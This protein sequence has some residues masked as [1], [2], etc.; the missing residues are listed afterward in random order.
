MNKRFKILHTLTLSIFLLLATINSA[1]ASLIKFSAS[2]DGLQANAGAGT[3]S[4]A[5]GWGTMFLDDVT[6]D[7]SW[8]ISWSGLQAAVTA[9]HFHGPALPNQNAGVQVTIDVSSNPSSGNTVL[10]A[11][12]ASDLMN[13][14]WYVNIHSSMFPAGEIR[15]Q[16]LQDVSAPS[17]ILILSLSLSG[18]VFLR[19]RTL[20]N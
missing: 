7:F 3:G 19:R 18:F 11:Q 17:T 12:Q 1:T 10:T 2:L 4:L 13:S 15:G 8:E 14:L 20:K 16:V 9:A 6:N 5:S